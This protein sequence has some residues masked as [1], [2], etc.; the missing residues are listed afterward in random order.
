MPKLG[1]LGKILVKLPSPRMMVRPE[2]A[3][4]AI[5][6]DA[7]L[8]PLLK[9]PL[10]VARVNRK[11]APFPDSILILELAGDAPPSITPAS[12]QHRNKLAIFIQSKQHKD[13]EQQQ[14]GERFP[15]EYQKCEKITCVPWLFVLI[16]DSDHI[17]KAANIPLPWKG[18]GFFVGQDE[19][20]DLYGRPLYL[21]RKEEWASV[22]ETT[23]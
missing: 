23:P 1:G 14:V 13:R 15:K 4:E 2:R 5:V 3:I 12:A 7:S 20:E 19:L 9:G 8:E 10:P 11:M 17:A 16:S 22:E 18:N 6:D 21:I